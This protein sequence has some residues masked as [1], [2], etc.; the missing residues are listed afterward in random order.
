M[1]TI[2][3]LEDIKKK[4]ESSSPAQ[5]P[6][7]GPNKRQLA[8]VIV[9]EPAPVA[10]KPAPVAPEEKIGIGTFKRVKKEKLKS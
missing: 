10:A 9:E 3:E 5:Q 6:Q 2:Q 1:Y 7:Q 8:D 4:F